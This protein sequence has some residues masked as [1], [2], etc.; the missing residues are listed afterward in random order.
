[1]SEP[2]IDLIEIKHN[3]ANNTR[4]LNKFFVIRVL[5]IVFR[6]FVYFLL[7]DFEKK[8]NQK[9]KRNRFEW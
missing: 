8:K 6:N 7:T 2:F 5:F 4:M 1:M 3:N 9:T